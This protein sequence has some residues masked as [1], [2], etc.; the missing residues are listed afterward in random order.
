MIPS[1]LYVRNRLRLE[2]G[3]DFFFAPVIISHFIALGAI[4]MFAGNGLASKLTFVMFVVL[5]IRAFWG[6][7]PYR[8]KVKAMKIG[9]WEVIYGT[10]TALSV[11]L[12]Y[13]LKI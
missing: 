11:V 10:L 4:G 12:G 2:K 5:L 6:L 9:V 7:S 3:K 1:I 8:K 13:Y